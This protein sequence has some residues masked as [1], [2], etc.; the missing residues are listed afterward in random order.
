LL[1]EDW[2]LSIGRA[3]INDQESTINNESQIKD[4]LINN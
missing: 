4:H 3:R 2:R 1:I